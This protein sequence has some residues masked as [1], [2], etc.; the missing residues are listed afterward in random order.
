MFICQ[1]FPAF[2]H[3]YLANRRFAESVEKDY[4][5]PALVLLATDGKYHLHSLSYI[6][7]TVSDAFW[8]RLF[9]FEINFYATLLIH[10]TLCVLNG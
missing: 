8:K 4:P 6:G 5:L 9:A 7:H 2:G 1:S 3:N 10:L